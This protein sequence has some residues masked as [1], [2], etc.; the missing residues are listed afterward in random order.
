MDTGDLNSQ[1]SQCITEVLNKGSV[2][3]LIDGMVVPSQVFPLRRIYIC[4]LYS[5][6]VIT[7]DTSINVHN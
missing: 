2:I 6:K 5:L 3:L 4:M 7:K 1:I